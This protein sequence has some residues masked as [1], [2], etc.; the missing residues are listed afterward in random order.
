MNVVVIG[1]GLAGMTAARQIAK[2]GAK[3]GRGEPSAEGV[4]A[5]VV[6]PLLTP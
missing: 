1:G 5:S 3:V 6:A 4:R 2:R